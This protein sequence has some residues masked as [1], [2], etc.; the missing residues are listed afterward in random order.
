MQRAAT[1]TILLIEA[2]ISLRRMI[3]LGLQYRGLQVIE[4][5]S[6]SHLPTLTDQSLDLVVLDI[7]G[8]AGNNHELL[9]EV[10]V[11]PIL[12]SIPI[13]ALAWETPTLVNVQR[14]NL[15]DFLGH[16]NSLDHITCLT[17]EAAS[18]HK[19]E[20]YLS[21]YSSTPTPSICP[22]ITAVGLLLVF[23]GLLLQIIVAAIGILIVV[24]ALLWWTLG[25]KTASKPLAIEAS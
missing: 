16:Q 3:A 4:T 10:Q 25:T 24:A 1:H 18:A 19:Q 12:S 5:S 11:H 20:A 9:T 23:I 15:S 13:V 6:P 7:D 21:A 2:D 8:E 14:D 22:L 17:K